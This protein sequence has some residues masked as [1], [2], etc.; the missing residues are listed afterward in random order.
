MR[1]ALLI[2]RR[3]L[4]GLFVTPLGWLLFSVALSVNGLFFH[5]FLR[6]NQ[7]DVD[8]ALAVSMGEGLSFWA[9][10]LFLPPLLTMRMISEESR[11]GMLE[12]LLTAP[13][14]DGAVIVGKALAAATFMALLWAT[15]VGYALLLTALGTSPD[16]GLVVANYL[17]AVLTSTLF[18][19]IGLVASA[20]TNA[21]LLSAFL[22]MI[23]NIAVLAVGL[24]ARPLRELLGQGFADAIL[25]KIAVADA[26]FSSFLRGAFDTSALVFFAAWIC[27]LLFLATRLLEARRW[28]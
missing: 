19:S 6:G 27:V 9:L 17:G 24:V 28:L 4:A 12:F 13:V 11:T 18:C 7:G 10:Q 8:D 26:L 22:A 25:S 3:E 23:F 15:V 14:R 20:L 21:P 5:T 16:W 1:A 2:Y